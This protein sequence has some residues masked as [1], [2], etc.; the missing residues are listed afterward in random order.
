MT[1]DF[2]A[3]RMKKIPFSGI[4]KVFERVNALEQNGARILHFEIGRPDFD[5]PLHIKEAAKSALDQG[6]VH[7]TSN[8]GL[9]E[10]TRLIA[11]RLARRTGVT[12]A[13]SGEIIVTVGANEAVFLAML[14]SL[15]PGDEVLL[16]D[17]AWLHYYHCATMAHAVPV[18]VPMRAKQGFSLDP[19]EVARRITPK[20][21]MLVINTPHNPTGAVLDKDCLNALAS[22]A[23]KHDLLVLSDEIYED[24]IYDGAEHVSI[25]SLDGMRERTV[26]VNGFSKNYSMTGWRLGYL[27][28]P[29]ELTSVFNRVHQYTTVCAVTFAQYGAIAA[30]RGGDACIKEM[31]AEFDRRRKLMVSSLNAMPGVH[32]VTPKGAFYAFPA[33][34]VPGMDSVAVADYLLEHAHIAVVPGT[35]FGQCGEGHIRLSYATSYDNIRI[36]MENMHKAMTE[37]TAR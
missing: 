22:L 2:E 6:H 10:L 9:A 33:I 17:P 7:Y 37:L 26:V 19:D 25:A 30:L 29:R 34:Q 13:P 21:K 27:A 35:V 4:R 12:Y 11:E 24:M 5:T 3:D 1:R 15:N 28:A 18:P 31:V 8:L 16:P 32:C 23:K 36:G 20:T 14:G